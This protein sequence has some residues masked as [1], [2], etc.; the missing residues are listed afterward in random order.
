MRII[1]VAKGTQLNWEHGRRR[2]TGPAQVLLAMIAKKPSLLSELFLDLP[3]ANLAE[4]TDADRSK[5][6]PYGRMV[7]AAYGPGN[8]YHGQNSYLEAVSTAERG[9]VVMARFHCPRLSGPVNLSGII[10]KI[11]EV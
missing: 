9:R 8:D 6:V 4:A 1:G 3:C 11:Q 10:R 7:P 5:R 2:P